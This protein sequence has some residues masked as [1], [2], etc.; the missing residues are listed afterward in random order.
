MYD[1]IAEM[2]SPLWKYCFAES[3]AGSE[4]PVIILPAITFSATNSSK[5][6]PTVAL[7]AKSAGTTNPPYLGYSASH[8]FSCASVGH[9]KVLAS[10]SMPFTLKNSLV[11]KDSTAIVAMMIDEL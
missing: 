6:I 9:A 10:L 1:S 3:P 7:E 8:A 11:R 4:S 2:E 5:G